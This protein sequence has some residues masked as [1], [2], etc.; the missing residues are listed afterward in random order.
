MFSRLQTP[1]NQFRVF[2]KKKV[3]LNTE[4]PTYP[5]FSCPGSLQERWNEKAKMRSQ[6]M[7]K[8]ARASVE[9]WHQIVNCDPSRVH[10]IK[11]LWVSRSKIYYQ[12][13]RSI[14]KWPDSFFISDFEQKPYMLTHFNTVWNFVI[15]RISGI[16]LTVKFII[17]FL[18]VTNF[19][20]N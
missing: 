17:H 2:F 18:W 3:V 16:K 20:E 15:K 6:K 4:K 10:R 19:F 8:C 14:D 12:K 7:Q 5:S 13:W 9:C 11:L 1:E